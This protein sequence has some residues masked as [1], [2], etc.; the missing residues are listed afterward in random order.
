VTSSD[1]PFSGRVRGVA[2]RIDELGR[3]VVP[4]S[5]RKVLGIRDGDLLDMTVEGDAVVLRRLAVHCTFCD[6][7]HDLGS[8]REQ[9]LCR[10]CARAIAAGA[11][12]GNTD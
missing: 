12:A 1:D 8:F 9:P 11:E 6:A 5:Y 2:R 3:I 4:S 7:G 10:A